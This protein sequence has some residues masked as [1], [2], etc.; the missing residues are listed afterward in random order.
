MSLRSHRWRTLSVVVL[1]IL[2]L[3]SCSSDG[4]SDGSSNGAA[5]GGQCT[6][7][8][9]PVINFAAYS[10]PREAT[11]RSSRSSSRSGKRRTT[12]RT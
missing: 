10:T 11:G 12:I 2:T 8:E 7:A 6:P 3:A 1:P 4:G 9:T 5:G